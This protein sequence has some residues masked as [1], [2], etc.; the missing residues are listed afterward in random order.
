MPLQIS[1]MEAEKPKSPKTVKK[2][3]TIDLDDA[4][5]S[6]ENMMRTVERGENLPD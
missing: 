1:T 2:P 3:M 5:F 4:N 6:L